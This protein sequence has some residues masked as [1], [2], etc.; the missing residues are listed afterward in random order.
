MTATI[1]RAEVDAVMQRFDSCWHGKSDALFTYVVRE[2]AY[3][4]R[5]EATKAD[6]RQLDRSEMLDVAARL[7]ALADKYEAAAR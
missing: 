6:Y 5:D 4:L 7:E 1:P 3:D 2:Y